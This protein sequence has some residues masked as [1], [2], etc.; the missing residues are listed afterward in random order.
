MNTLEYILERFK[1]EWLGC[2][3]GDRP[4]RHEHE[5]KSCFDCS[6]QRYERRG[7]VDIPNFGRNQLP[8][9]FNELGFKR[10][11]E[12]GVMKGEYS[13]VICQASPGIHLFLV[14]PWQAYQGYGLGNQETMDIYHAEAMKR[15]ERFNN[16][17]V[18][19]KFS[20]EAA[21]DFPDGSLDFVYIDAAHD[22]VNVVN[23]L[24]AWEPK[25]RSNG[26]VCGHD[27]VMRGLGPKVF[28]KANRK[29]HVKQAVDGYTL[30]YLI[31]PYFIL[32]RKEEVE[33]EI[34][35]KIRS[36]MWVKD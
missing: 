28:G 9:L 24:A 30:A 17:S 31:D 14:D 15:L 19:R 2:V 34:R 10:G 18:V 12:I 4:S 35:D 16:F 27:Y 6:C 5:V 8:L 1:V 23:D 29:F 13:E 32:G 21:K 11:A 20:V 26:L 3:C 7:P 22:F 25:V 36:F 33:G